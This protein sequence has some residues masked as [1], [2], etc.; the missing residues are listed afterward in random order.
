VLPA[1]VIEQKLNSEITG[2]LDAEL[3]ISRDFEINR[4]RKL[5]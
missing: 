3:W 1:D 5:L 2:W 4:A